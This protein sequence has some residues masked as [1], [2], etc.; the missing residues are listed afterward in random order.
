MEKENGNSNDSG[1]AEERAHTED[2]KSSLNR[3]ERQR[4][5]KPWDFDPN[6]D[7][8]RREAEEDQL[9]NGSGS[10]PSHG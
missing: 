8:S 7:V 9:D 1:S 2:N 5:A 6:E 10:K 4:R 3:L